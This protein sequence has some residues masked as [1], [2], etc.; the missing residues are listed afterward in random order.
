VI[1]MLLDLFLL[2]FVDGFAGLSLASVGFFYLV[3]SNLCRL[4]HL[5]ILVPVV[6]KDKV[7]PFKN[8]APYL[9][10]L[11]SQ[12]RM[13]VVLTLFGFSVLIT[14]ILLKAMWSTFEYTRFLVY[15]NGAIEGTQI[16]W[17]S[18]ALSL[19]IIGRYLIG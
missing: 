1:V 14:D 17:T 15:N 12:L 16:S 3:V 19:V 7:D 2:D 4:L 9:S 11:I 18:A 13:T 6:N 8:F 5:S 10:V